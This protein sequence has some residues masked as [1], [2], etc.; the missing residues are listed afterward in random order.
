MARLPLLAACLAAAAAA[1]APQPQ[2]QPKKPK[3]VLG[4]VID[5]F[6]FDYFYRFR[7]NFNGGLARMWQQGAVFT[8]AFYE[9]APT[10]TAIG[11]ATFLTGAFP[12][13]SGIIGN[14]WHDRESRGEV[15]SVSDKRTE[16]LGGKGEGSSPR[17][18]LVSTLGDELKM[19]GRGKPKVVGISIKDRSSILPSGHM[20]D[21]AYWFDN[22]SGNM[23]S[24][25]YYF[26]DLP[27][28]VKAYNASRPADKYMSAKWTP[29]DDPKAPPF[30]TMASAPG[31]NYWKNMQRTPYGNEMLEDFAERAVVAEKLGQGGGPLPDV[32]T[33][34]FSSND[35]VGHDNGPDSPH[36]RDVAIRVDRTIGKLFRFLDAKVGMQNVLV[37]LSAD[38]GVA[39]VPEVNR[40]R[41]MPGGRADGAEM[42]KQLEAMLVERYG[43][44]TWIPKG[45]ELPQVFLNRELMA[46][47]RLNP[48]T[49]R[50]QAAN[51][52]RGQEQVQRVYTWDQLAAGGGG[53]MVDQR[54]RNG[55]HPLRSPDLMVIRSPYWL[56]TIGPGK[57]TT[58]NTP[59]NYDAHVP[60]IFMGPGIKPGKY[61]GRAKPNDIAPTL[62]TMLEVETPSGAA[63]RVLAEMLR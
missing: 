44:G 3:L 26:D 38:H 59:Y 12:S 57:G 21:A 63:G 35:Y 9:H 52:L 42:T 41:K 53:D 30:E 31:E 49:V 8:N 22:L 58:H 20:A 36:V 56:H 32:L 45:G 46:T 61:H 47:K 51:W 27:A 55:F 50:A 11:H 15:T 25:T 39:P 5:Q 18:L 29:I 60:V 1:Q 48:A 17:R 43:G 33:L 6:R 14:D 62:A 7:D 4:I 16:L 24:S 28:W 37:V 13:V 54:V 19:A 10:V 2:P 23:V 40:D 34:S